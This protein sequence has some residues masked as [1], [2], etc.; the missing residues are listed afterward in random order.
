[1]NEFFIIRHGEAEHLINGTGGG[2]VDTPLTDVG[3]EQ[4]RSIAYRL[5]ELVNDKSCNI[6]S[7]DLHRAHETATIIGDV[8]NKDPLVNSLIRGLS[9]GIAGSMQ[10]QEAKLVKKPITLPLFDWIPYQDAESWA[11]MQ[12]RV[13][14]FMEMVS[15]SGKETSI[16]V[17]HGNSGISILYW[18]L[19]INRESLNKLVKPSFQLDPCSL[20]H[21]IKKENDKIRLLKI[22]DMSHINM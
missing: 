7:S 8:L 13:N 18:L 19:G 9:L 21:L 15:E 1:M 22:N 17:T 11:M 20:T 4:S 6:Y 5:K 3:R 2:W 14:L 10:K 12:E 16:I